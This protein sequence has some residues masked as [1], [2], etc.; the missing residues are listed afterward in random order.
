M[1]FRFLVRT[2]LFDRFRFL[3]IVSEHPEAAM[4]FIAF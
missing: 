1:L 2:L 3:V 4:M